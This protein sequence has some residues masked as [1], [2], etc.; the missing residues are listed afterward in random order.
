MDRNDENLEAEIKNTCINFDC[1]LHDRSTY[2]YRAHTQHAYIYIYSNRKE[3]TIQLNIER[4]DH[5]FN[6]KIGSKRTYLYMH[7]HVIEALDHS[8]MIT[9]HLFLLDS[10]SAG[11]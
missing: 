3:E 9:A 10:H 5:I 1:T 6:L 11:V 8:F 7:V 4:Y 2:T